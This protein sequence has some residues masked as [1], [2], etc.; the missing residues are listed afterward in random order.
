M[1]KHH[2]TSTSTPGLENSRKRIKLSKI[3]N[4]KH[5]QQSQTL[6]ITNLP[7]DVQYKIVGY[8]LEDAQRGCEHCRS[9]E[10]FEVPQH[11]HVLDDM[12]RLASTC[13]LMYRV[14]FSFLNNDDMWNKYIPRSTSPHLLSLLKINNVKLPDL[15]ENLPSYYWYTHAW[16]LLVGDLLKV[17]NLSRHNPLHVTGILQTV[18][19]FDPK[20]RKITIGKMK[21]KVADLPS[22]LIL[23]KR[24]FNSSASSLEELTIHNGPVAIR[25]A[26]LATKFTKLRSITFTDVRCSEKAIMSVRCILEH[27]RD[28]GAPLQELSLPIIFLAK[29]KLPLLSIVAPSVRSLHLHGKKFSSNDFLSNL[30][31]Y[32]SDQLNKIFTNITSL[33]IDNPCAPQ[34]AHWLLSNNI[35]PKLE[36][37]EHIWE[38]PQRSTHLRSSRENLK[39]IGPYLKRLEF[40]VPMVRQYDDVVNR[41]FTSL[42]K[43]AVNLEILDVRAG[44]PDV[45]GLSTY[46][47]TATK[48]REVNIAAPRAGKTR[49]DANASEELMKAL[50]NSASKLEK[51]CQTQFTCQPSDAI[52]L[53]EKYRS[54]L[55]CL[56]LVCKSTRT[57]YDRQSLNLGVE[58]AEKI[59]NAVRT[60]CLNLENLDVGRF[61]YGPADKKRPWVHTQTVPPLQIREAI[62]ETTRLLPKFKDKSTEWTDPFYGWFP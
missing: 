41:Y 60:H 8:L 2:H 16:Y 58:D 15:E 35:L 51:I 61:G 40:D 43:H 24:L 17:A 36:Q 30:E 26:I 56:R 31:L 9:N 4:E 3:V 21:N 47:Q 54:D 37:L 5:P 12:L 23:L 38:A 59:Y 34:A 49:I 22:A 7:Q 32:E 62:S 39:Q 52:S 45:S 25:Y 14:V 55:K 50:L 6:R 1:P 20:L 27:L 13:R 11:Y 44:K 57:V 33:S 48:L 19:S 18:S 42:A 46:I 10:K 28:C 29:R 53:L